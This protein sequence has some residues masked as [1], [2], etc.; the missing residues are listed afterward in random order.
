M[1]PDYL[2][3]TKPKQRI[4]TMKYPT[5]KESRLAHMQSQEEKAQAVQTAIQTA[6]ADIKEKLNQ[7]KEVHAKE[8]ADFK[9]V[10]LGITKQKVEE[11]WTAYQ[12]AVRALEDLQK[13]KERSLKTS[14]LPEKYRKQTFNKD[15]YIREGLERWEVLA[16]ALRLDDTTLINMGLNRGGLQEELESLRTGLFEVGGRAKLIEAIKAISGRIG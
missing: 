16:T 14:P 11:L 3:Q 5:Y 2:N 7:M 12:N 8:L 15:D 9:E 10:E 6:K 4:E 1:C 13:A